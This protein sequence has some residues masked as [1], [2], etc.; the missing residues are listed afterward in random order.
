MLK[1][2]SMEEV[3]IAVLSFSP[4]LDKDSLGNKNVYFVS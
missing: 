1:V 2:G 3:V 4:D